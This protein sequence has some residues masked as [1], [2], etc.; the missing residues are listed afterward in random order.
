VYY[1]PEWSPCSY[2]SSEILSSAVWQR[3]RNLVKPPE[4]FWAVWVF[5]VAAGILVPLLLVMLGMLIQLLQLGQQSIASGDASPMPEVLKLG[6]FFEMPT[7]LLNSGGSVLRGVLGLV[8]LF[9]IVLALEFISMLASY[10]AALHCALEI[11]VDV[12]RK[13]YDKSGAMAIEKGLSGQQEAIRDMVFVHVPQI[14]EALGQ[15]Y[16]VFPRHPV[17]SCILILLA[18]S[19]QASIT[20][21]ALVGAVIVWFLFSSL[22]VA[23]RKKRP[24]QFERARATTEQLAY[25]CETAPLLAS[26]HNQ[27][28]TRQQFEGLL[29][30]Y[31]DAQIK[32]ADG[33]VWKS[34]AMLLTGTVLIAFLTIV[35][36]I[37]F[38]DSVDSLQFGE[39][40]TLCLAVGIAILG[41]HRFAKSYRRYRA[42]ENA[43]GQ[44]ARYLEQITPKVS[45]ETG[46]QLLT[47]KRMELE[48]VTLRDSTSQKL[49]ED[50]ST[51]L[52][53]GQLTAIVSSEQ[54]QAAA[55]AELVLGFGRPVSGRILIDG[56]D[57]TDIDPTGMHPLSLWVESRGPLV[58]G[59][60]EENLW[61]GAA[62]DATIDLMALAKR[63]HVADAVLNLPDSLATLV[64]PDEDRI[65]LDD[66]FRLGLTRA[67]IKKPT[68]VVAHE[69]H[70]RVKL[71]TE[72]DTLDAILQLKSINAILVV[73]PKRLTTLRAADQIIVLHQ[74]KVAGIGKHA[75]LLE[76][77]EIYRHLN[78]MQFSPFAET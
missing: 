12:Q 49:L 1:G 5:G 17:Q 18:V 10:R 46:S 45:D 22:D 77:C 51:T 2:R 71:T 41:F 39:L 75:Q 65:Q 13:L 11:S 28:E 36:S 62:P 14:R 52:V 23:R 15:W 70:V 21:L 25:L 60:L 8:A 67:L 26:V 59:S 4:H 78:Y 38:L 27:E 48:H 42:C 43:A 74:H 19:I 16:R 34:P 33:G 29:D 24:V 54:V 3:L 64:A 6:S 31:R 44:L 53:A 9:I 66:L 40:A 50:I 56:K 61:A 35:T 47:F 20:I 72:T 30:S 32:I 73:L 68:L 7:S 69:P 37:R 55:L 57:L 76:T 58:H 63:M